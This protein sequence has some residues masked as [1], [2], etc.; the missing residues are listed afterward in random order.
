MMRWNNECEI[1]HDEFLCN[2]YWLLKKEITVNFIYSVRSCLVRPSNFK[3][4]QRKEYDYSNGLHSILVLC[5]D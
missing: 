5:R 2:N 4:S 1:L 3:L